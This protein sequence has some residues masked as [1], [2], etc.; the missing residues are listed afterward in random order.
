ML[1]RGWTI[2]CALVSLS[3][4]SVPA[5]AFPPPRHHH[6]PSGDTNMMPMAPPGAY[7]HSAAGT[8]S[9]T[10]GVFLPSANGAS[11]LF[12]RNDIFVPMRGTF[13][14]SMS[15]P[16]TLRTRE[17]FDPAT[18][19][20]TPSAKGPIVVTTQGNFLSSSPGL[21]QPS[22][23]PASTGAFSRTM[24]GAYSPTTGTFVPS[25]AGASVLSS[26]REVF[27]PYAGSFVPDKNGAFV[28]TTKEAY[29][30]ATGMLVPSANGTYTMVERGTY[31]SNLAG[32]VAPAFSP[33]TTGGTTP[34]TNSPPMVGTM[35]TGNPMNG[36]NGSVSPSAYSHLL[37]HY[38]RV[39]SREE[40]LAATLA[41]MYNPALGNPYG[42]PMSNP[43]ATSAAPVMASTGTGY[44]APYY[45]TPGSSTTQTASAVTAY[46]PS[47]G[48]S[49]S[50]SVL[51]AFGI[52]TEA[53]QVQWPLALRLMPPDTKREL[54]DKLESQMKVAATQALASTA[55]PVILRE[56]KQTIDSTK[57]WL[58]DRR[59]NMSESTYLDGMDF[60]RRLEAALRK[61]DS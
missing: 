29:N 54:L 41:N 1:L 42:T 25:T 38:E 23:Y 48:P 39:L 14:P 22:T 11:S 57:A 53:G 3:M 17:T 43:Y 34:A 59:T 51:A 44:S 6:M 7:V 31:T 2:F 5:G 27:K 50:T 36:S 45:P 26:N 18:G 49:K 56:T 60:L 9:P 58:R 28:L 47:A 4:M 19:K 10:T 30:P 15:G 52:P 35:P 32:T 24:T 37:R 12:S 21:V 20:F 55:S 33:T 61:M 8:F 16:F 46:N 40:M 13:V